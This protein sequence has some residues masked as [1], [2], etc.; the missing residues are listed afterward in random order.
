MLGVNCKGLALLLA[1]LW[2]F[3]V[4]QGQRQEVTSVRLAKGEGWSD[5]KA[6]DQLNLGF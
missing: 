4:A 1:V 5:P 6:Q 2:V 3:G